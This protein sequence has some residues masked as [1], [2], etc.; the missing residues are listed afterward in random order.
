MCVGAVVFWKNGKIDHIETVRD[1]MR[2]LKMPCCDIPQA[3]P[4][5]VRPITPDECLCWVDF[6][7]LAKMKNMKLEEPEY[8]DT[9][10]YDAW[11]LY[12]Q[13]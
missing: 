12:E 1:L 5:E 13:K 6:E 2:A 9:D 7:A 8:D 3:P 10:H 4:K 11:G